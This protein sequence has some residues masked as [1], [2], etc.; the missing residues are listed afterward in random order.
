MCTELY[1]IYAMLGK[2]RKVT[3]QIVNNKTVYPFVITVLYFVFCVWQEVKLS[4][5]DYYKTAQEDAIKDFLL[6]IQHYEDNYETIDE[7]LDK[8][9]IG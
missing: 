1:A 7:E 9:V 6:R 8:W 4:S 5:P 2:C 3:K